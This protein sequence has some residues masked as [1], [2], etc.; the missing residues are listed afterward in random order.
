MKSWLVETYV[1]ANLE[2]PT[3]SLSSSKMTFSPWMTK[4]SKF[5]TCLR[6]KPQLGIASVR[7]QSIKGYFVCRGG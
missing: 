3:Y 2:M 7:G 6:Y 5:Y 1:N 4:Q